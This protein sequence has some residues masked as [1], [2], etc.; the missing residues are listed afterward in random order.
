MK[1]YLPVVLTA[2]VLYYVIN[3]PGPAADFV[4]SA[5]SGLAAFTAALAGGAQ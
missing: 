2:F 5:T 1:K 3:N 4:R